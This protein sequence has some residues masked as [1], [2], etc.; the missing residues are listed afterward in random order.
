M[1][2]GQMADMEQTWRRRP[3][4]DLT[5]WEHW[6]KQVFAGLTSSSMACRREG[7]SE[8]GYRLEPHT[9]QIC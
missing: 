6:T 3:E 7:S 9:S 8:K 1:R 5:W 4:A 2:C